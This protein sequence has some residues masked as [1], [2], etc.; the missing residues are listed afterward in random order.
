MNRMP[1]TEHLPACTHFGLGVVPYSP[2]ARGVLTGKYAP[3]VAPEP[4]TRAAAQDKRMM[5]TEWRHES[6]E[7]AQ[8]IRRHAEA[9]GMTAGQ[10]A[11]LWVLNNAL[12]TA[13]IAV[14]RP[15]VACASSGDGGRSRQT[16]TSAG[17]RPYCVMPVPLGLAL[18]VALPLRAD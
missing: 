4:G 5:Q 1:E 3:N 18:R 13:T 7:L 9:R 6:L 14:T 15:P 8:E 12:V 11:V 10:F 17:R 2:L 16:P